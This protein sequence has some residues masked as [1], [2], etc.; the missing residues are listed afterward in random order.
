VYLHS[1]FIIAKPASSLRLTILIGNLDTKLMVFLQAKFPG[2]VKA[3][4]KENQR[5]AGIDRYG[6]DFD[7][8][9]IM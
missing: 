8:C 6:E 2:E 7:K 4:Q 1:S 9:A 3:K 5:A